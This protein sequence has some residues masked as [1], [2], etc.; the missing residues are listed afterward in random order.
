MKDE[1]R[2]FRAVCVMMV[3]S[4]AAALAYEVVWLRMLT[5]VFGVTVHAVAALTALYMGGLALGAAGAGRF[6]GG[7]GDWLRVYA[8]LEAGAGLAALAATWGM[9]WLP[10]LAAAGSEGP[11]S[12][13]WRIALAAPLLL[14][15]T[16]LLGATLPVLV[17]FWELD[18][19]GSGGARPTAEAVRASVGTLYGWN[20]AGAVVGLLFAGFISIGAW[21][22]TA[23]ALVAAVCN[24]SAAAAAFAFSGHGAVLAGGGGPGAAGREGGAAAPTEPRPAAG[25]G[26]PAILWAYA[27]S[28]FCALGYEVL[29]SRQL[30]LILGNSTYAFSALLAMFLGG[31]ALGSHAAAHMSDA[32]SDPGGSAPL[33]A[34]GAVQLALAAAALW[35]LA[36]FRF[37]GLQL[38]SPDFLYSPIR[39]A[40]DIPMLF[41]QAGVLVFP[42][43]LAM[44]AL[45]P[46]A[47]R[48]YQDGREAAGS[49][50]GRLYAS[51]TLGG[52]LGSLAVGFWGIE[53]LGSHRSFLVLAGISTVLGAAALAAATASRAAP[54]GRR[55]AAHPRRRWAAGVAA[56]LCVSGAL[57]AAGDPTLDILLR[58]FRGH[59]GNSGPV[60]VLFHKESAAA[61]VTGLSSG[62]NR[63]LFINGIET[64]G[65]GPQGALM[66]LLPNVFLEAPRSALVIC[67][68]VGTTFRAASLLTPEVDAVELVGDVAAAAPFF[69][70]DALEHQRRPGR[71]VSI[72]DGRSF[73]LRSRRRYDSIIVDAAPPLYS[74]GAVNLY[75]REF[76]ESA[77]GHLTPEGVFT[78][79]L[80]LGSFEADYWGILR[81]AADV[82]PHVAVWNHPKI[83]GILVFGSA[84]PFAW[85]A[86]TLDRRL[87]SRPLPELVRKIRESHIREGFSLSEGELRAHVRSFAPVTD[88]RPASEFPLR[89]FLTGEPRQTDHDFLFKARRS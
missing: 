62:Q 55:A 7:W 5:R 3:L 31:I 70:A 2:V 65:I 42:A 22:E 14:P 80:P 43:S 85:P 32:R 12:P 84:R 63:F 30:I 83:E 57:A 73:L 75:T 40:F 19:S 15:P 87:R 20:T 46:L 11:L 9:R 66:A 8:G 49:S 89:R 48:V 13:V 53:R 68:G 51:N 69:Y 10:A 37:L 45:F 59:P 81:A 74:S 47:L 34:F 4:G 52:I 28:G 79:W 86:G 76:L 33:A 35:S 44:G 54:G 21:G 58:R 17:R 71:T 16:V 25:G 50:V 72:D 88:D 29:W 61:A 36:G 56:L 67:F 26:S 39:G 18:L 64:S 77:R 82:F 78:L 1:R 6:G 38:T 60:Q 41:L 23:T 24:L 27:L